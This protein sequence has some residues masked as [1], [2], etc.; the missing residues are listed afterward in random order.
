MTHRFIST[1]CKTRVHS[2]QREYLSH[3]HV[4]PGAGMRILREDGWTA[5]TKVGFETRRLHCQPLN[6][7]LIVIIS[8]SG[9]WPL[10]AV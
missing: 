4:L 7:D 10:C 8:S 9:R 5:V 3:L 1:R 6:H 2:I